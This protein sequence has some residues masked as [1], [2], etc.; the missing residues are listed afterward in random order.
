MCQNCESNKNSLQGKS[1]VFYEGIAQTIVTH[2]KYHK[3][4]SL[5]ALIAHYMYKTIKHDTFDA[6]LPVPTSFRRLLQKGYH[7]TAIIAQHL[8][9]LTH[10]PLLTNCLKKHH[11]KRQVDCD[12]KE[13]LTNVKNSFY[14][15]KQNKQHIKNKHILLIDD[16]FTTGSTLYECA[17]ILKK[18]GA[19]RV[20]FI[21]FARSRQR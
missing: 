20:S 5:G 16:V 8:S 1:L 13:R 21:T 7:H 15:N 12:Q 6:I 19:R 2:F 3:R 9:K 18:G 11:T 14:L 17:R 10:K 4:F